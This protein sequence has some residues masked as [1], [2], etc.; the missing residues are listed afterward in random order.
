M[1]DNSNTDYIKENQPCLYHFLDGLLNENIGCEKKISRNFIFNNHI[2]DNVV[3]L[4]ITSEKKKFYE[5]EKLK[6]I[7]YN[8]DNIEN[9]EVIWS[10][11]I[12]LEIIKQ[13]FKYC[14]CQLSNN[15]HAT[16]LLFFIKDN[17]LYTL[18]INSGAGIKD[19]HLKYN[20]K[21]ND[22]YVPYI[23]Y[24]IGNIT[25]YTTITKLKKILTLDLLYKEL[26]ILKDDTNKLYLFNIK[27]IIKFLK[28]IEPFNEFTFDI[29]TEEKDY[30]CKN[31]NDILNLPGRIEKITEKTIN[32]DIFYSFFIKNL[33]KKYKSTN[34]S[35]FGVNTISFDN[36]KL[37]DFR[38]DTSKISDDIINKII[39]HYNDNNLYINDQESGSCTWFSIYWAFILYNII[40]NNNY[41][42]YCD[43]IKN[44]N[45]ICYNKIN[46]L[47]RQNMQ[48]V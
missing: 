33:N 15:D 7:F 19:T 43:L 47:F 14:I 45:R 3:F 36:T 48:N 23:G 2:D 8:K 41:K 29:K 39:L 4:N 5:N 24:K 25:D 38:E 1:N 44:I 42:I 28:N 12:T 26:T 27:T 31:V 16:S 32:F 11:K 30:K 17:I 40:V 18:S 10:D 6:L 20:D 22:K 37:D 34:L 46:E 9:A 35:E 13:Y 21:Y